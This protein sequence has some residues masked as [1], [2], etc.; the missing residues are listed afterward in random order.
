MGDG[1]SYPANGIMGSPQMRKAPDW[2]DS[3]GHKI[4]MQPV[5]THYGRKP[6][7]GLPPLNDV[8]VSFQEFAGGCR[9]YIAMDHN[10]VVACTFGIEGML[11]KLQELRIELANYKTKADDLIKQFAANDDTVK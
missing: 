7:F 10:G 8:S 9:C 1:P 6:L 11:F 2:A 5:L 4:W 3:Y